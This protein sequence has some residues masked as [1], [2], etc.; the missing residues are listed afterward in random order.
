[1]SVRLEQGIA[2]L[3][4]AQQFAVASYVADDIDNSL[5]QRIDALSGNAANVT[6]EML[7]HPE[8]A[9]NFLRERVALN[10]MFKAGLVFISKDGRGIADYPHIPERQNGSYEGLEYFR[11]VLATGRPSVGKARIGRFTK[12]PGIALAVPVKNV[13]GEIVAVFAGFATLSDAT[14][15]G[16]VEQT[17]IGRSGYIVIDDPRYRLIV[18]SSDPTRILGPM[19]KPGV[20]VMLDR[21]VAGFE[22]SGISINSRGVEV[23]TSAKRIPTSGWITQVILPTREAFTP[24]RELKNTAYWIA[25]ALSVLVALLTWLIVRRAFRPLDTASAAIRSMVDG[26]AS[27]LALPV[28]SDDE[29]GNLLTSFNRLVQQRKHV[30]EALAESENALRTI[31]DT[32]PACVKV[33]AP[34]GTLLQ[35]NRAGLDMI[36]A[37]S[38]AQ[39][40]GRGMTGIIVPEYRDAFTALNRSVCQGQA[41]TLEFEIVGFKGT[42]RWLE[43]HAVPLRDAEGRIKGLLGVARDITERKQIHEALKESEERF[44]TVADYNYDWEYWRGPAK[45]FLYMSPACERITGYSQA[46]FMADS[47]LVDR[48]VHADDRQ[49]MDGHLS[50]YRDDTEHSLDFRIVGK[51]GGIRWIAHGCR[52]VYGKSGEFLGRRVSN[53]DITERKRAEAEMRE[54]KERLALALEASSLSIW[55]FD[56][57]AGIVYMDDRWANIVEEPI[58]ATIKSIKELARNTHAQDVERVIK[59][60]VNAFKGDAPLFQEEFRVKTGRGEWKWIRCSGKVVERDANGRAIRAIGTNLDIH[61]RKAAEEKIRQLAYY[62]TLTELPNRRLLHDRLNQS[63]SQAKRFERSLAVMFLDLDNF[64]RINDTLGHDAGDELLKEVARRL[65]ACIRTGDTLSRQGGDEFVVVLAEIAQPA[66]AARVAEKIIKVLDTPVRVANLDLNVTTSIGIS[67]YP[68]DGSDDVQELMK[69]ADIAM[70]AAKKAGRNGY[71][72]FDSEEPPAE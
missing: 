15:F 69:K 34:D 13:R 28:S 52:P 22:G 40:V 38:E 37:D 30:E 39:V 21:F 3:L 44:R 64:K 9:R 6:P 29:I 49:L 23:L 11:E 45:E 2:N 24:I 50:D 25:A 1:M 59:S 65:S 51:D 63:L 72:F 7:A 68:V 47:T 70:Y 12:L 10:S 46:E 27:L 31:I 35:M 57:G 61:E 26:K 16:R 53:R 67:V 19:A 8:K 48:V 18:T 60:A 42:H 17:R 5:R 41:G 55:S 62:D 43:T 71:R 66:D 54:A 20:N 58:G 33:L 36:E 32:E 4:F 14:L 56:I